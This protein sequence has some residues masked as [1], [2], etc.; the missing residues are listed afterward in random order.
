M[1]SIKD[2]ALQWK[3]GIKEWNDIL[4]LNGLN[5]GGKKAQEQPEFSKEL[6]KS[7]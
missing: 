1:F 7:V 4:F 2:V 5:Y 3:N 6:L